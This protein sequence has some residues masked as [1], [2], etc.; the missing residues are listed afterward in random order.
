MI[1]F[2]SMLK[3]FGTETLTDNQLKITTTQ[4]DEMAEA[5]MQQ[6]DLLAKKIQT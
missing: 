1:D 3:K 4:Y 6:L 2:E 5:D